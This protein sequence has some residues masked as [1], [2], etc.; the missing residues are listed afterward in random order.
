MGGTVKVNLDLRRKKLDFIKDK[1]G[2][3][4]LVNAKEVFV[5]PLHDY[6]KGFSLAYERFFPDG[7]YFYGRGDEDPNDKTL[8]KIKRSFLRHVLDDHL[9]EIYFKGKIPVKFHSWWDSYK[10]WKIYTLEKS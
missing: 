1:S 5:F 7:V 2:L 3:H 6:G 9:M 10:I 8:P 4:I